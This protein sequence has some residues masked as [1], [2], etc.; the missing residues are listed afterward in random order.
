MRAVCSAL[1]TTLVGAVTGSM[2]LEVTRE[3]RAGPHTES[4]LD[5]SS[6]LPSCP[7]PG[8]DQKRI[9]P[10][11]TQIGNSQ[12]TVRGSLDLVLMLKSFSNL[13][14]SQPSRIQVN[15]DVIS[16]LGSLAPYRSPAPI[17]PLGRC[18]PGTA[19]RL[20]RAGGSHIVGGGSAHSRGLPPASHLFTVL[21][22]S[23]LRRMPI[24][25]DLRAFQMLLDR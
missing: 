3:L 9:L 19:P 11:V 17:P 22:P 14:Y 6:D 10:S 25:V 21:L 15:I 20:L 1:S 5:L 23:A 2:R 16:H 12:E 24:V 18:R 4:V 8:A 13:S 7:F